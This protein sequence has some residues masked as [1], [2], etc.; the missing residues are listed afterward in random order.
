MYFL[1]IVFPIGIYPTY[2]IRTSIH[3]LTIHLI[4]NN[5][6]IYVVCVP[7]SEDSTV[8]N[9]PFFT[10]LLL[11][12]PAMVSGVCV[13]VCV[14]GM[15]YVCAWYMGLEESRCLLGFR[16]IVSQEPW[17]KIGRCSVPT[18][19]FLCLE[20]CLTYC[21]LTIPKLYHSDMIHLQLQFTFS[22]SHPYSPFHSINMHWVTAPYNYTTY[23]RCSGDDNN[24]VQAPWR[25]NLYFCCRGRGKAGITLPIR[26]L[27][28]YINC[29]K[30]HKGRDKRSIHIAM[31]EIDLLWKE[32]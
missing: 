7:A 30:W 8:N 5:L 15:L 11:F 10:W 9:F 16:I 4:S 2:F 22:N 32:R 24:A 25:W 14:A 31:G 29:D 23:A 28:I 6:F 19:Y 12:T 17:W 1:L 18:Q 20:I 27:I 13:F 26:V 3:L 21:L